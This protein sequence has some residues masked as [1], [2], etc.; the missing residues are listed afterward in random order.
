MSKN[1]VICAIEHVLRDEGCNEVVVAGIYDRV[2]ETRGNSNLGLQ[3]FLQILRE[4]QGEGLV[5]TFG[6][7]KEL[8]EDS[9]IARTQIH[10][11]VPIR[12]TGQV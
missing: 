1:A 2:K 4:L 5:E 10:P 9:L 8:S 12:R 7:P 3:E 11:S 6:E